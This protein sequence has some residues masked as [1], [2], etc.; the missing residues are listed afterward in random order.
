[1]SKRARRLVFIC[2]ECTDRCDGGTRLRKWLK[3]RIKRDGLKKEIR[4]VKTGCMGVCPRDRITIVPAGGR[5]MTVDPRRESRQ[6]VYLRI[7]EA[8]GAAV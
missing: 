3:R 5:C 4:L 6:S 8:D 7:V 1:M 2:R